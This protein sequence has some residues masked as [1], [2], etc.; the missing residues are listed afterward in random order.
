MFRW[1]LPRRAWARNSSPR[2]SSYAPCAAQMR[3]HARAFDWLPGGT[4]PLLA[5]QITGIPTIV[6]HHIAPRAKIETRNWLAR[7]PFLTKVKAFI[8]VSHANREAQIAHMGLPADRIFAVHNGIAP[9]G[10][11]AGSPED[12]AAYRREARLQICA[13]TGLPPSTRMVGC[14]G[15]LAEQK[16]YRWLLQSAPSSCNGCPMPISS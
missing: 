4:L 16:G 3:S 1:T 7:A 11:Q 5:G 6:T 13:E 15:R 8:A 12:W 2:S 10:P 9:L 14:V